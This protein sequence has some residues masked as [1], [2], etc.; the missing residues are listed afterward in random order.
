MLNK[1]KEER[2]MNTKRLSINKKKLKNNLKNIKGYLKDINTFI[3]IKNKS[4]LPYLSKTSKNAN[5]SLNKIKYK[6]KNSITNNNNNSI[7]TKKNFNGIN[8]YSPKAFSKLFK[9]NLIPPINKN[10]NFFKN[11]R[12]KSIN[13]LMKK[14]NSIQNINVQ[15]NN[16]N[17]IFNNDTAY[18]NS[19]NRS[20]FYPTYG[21]KVLK[22]NFSNYFYKS[23]SSLYT[24]KRIFHHYINESD[25]EKI[26]PENFFERNGAPKSRKKIN[27][28]Y[29]LNINYHK[30]LEEVK[31]NKSIAFKDDFNILKY[32]TTLIK[33]ISK[34]VSIEN[35]RELQSRYIQF[36]EK[37]SGR[38]VAPRG[39]LTNL[40]EKIKHNIPV[41][42]Y[43]K[44]KKLDKEKLLSRY[45][46]YKKA[47]EYIHNRF[48]K[49]Y[50]KK[51][52]RLKM[53][54]E[55]MSKNYDKNKTIDYNSNYSF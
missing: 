55:K 13:I 14:N 12:G 15:N 40:A 6:I 9:N 23:Q 8:A 27:E 39:R 22:K 1:I 26:N 41:F 52:K 50:S 20:K 16:A 36:N 45:N 10:K 4:K 35:L 31:H 2:E 49:M 46:Y 33:L 53:K 48:E 25:N 43:E 54:L 37:I 17:K 29:K 24:S 3:D 28:L 42:L 21:K 32:Q 5:N 11:I 44:I 19:A 30:R 47:N 18:N 51:Y 38:G 7:E 34:K